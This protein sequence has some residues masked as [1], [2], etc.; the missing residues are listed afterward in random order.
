MKRNASGA[1]ETQEE[2]LARRRISSR[3]SSQ[4]YRSQKTDE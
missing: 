4:L 3:L 1:L 2:T